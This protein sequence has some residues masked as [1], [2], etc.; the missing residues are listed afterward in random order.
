MKRK[1]IL[2]ILIAI[3]MIVF[4]QET[5]RGFFPQAWPGKQVDLLIENEGM[6]FAATIT[7]PEDIEQ[8]C[9]AVLLLPGFLGERD[10][11]PVTGT[12]VPAEGNRLQGMF[13]YLALELAKSGYISLRIDY[14]YSGRSEGYWQ[15][16]TF[17]SE[18]SDALAA[19]NYLES[20]PAVDKNK[21]AV[22]GLSLGGALASCLSSNQLI[23][24]IVLWSAAPE[25]NILEIM[26]P[27]EKQTELNETGIVT[28]T[29]PWGETTTMKK[30]FFDSLK[31]AN[32]LEEISKFKGPLLSICGSNDALVSPQPQQALKFLEI[33]EGEEKLVM[34]NADHTFDNFVG[35]NKISQAI[36]E[37]I[38]WLDMYL[39]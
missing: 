8:S 28:F 36:K 32:P 15:D 4:S 6:F 20:N 35:P 5:I 19:L 18:L 27:P 34:L 13:E 10:E 25:L 2:V 16:I 38:D 21:I 31:D 39:K 17:S 22:C 1:V 11:L 12:H 37:T 30:A 14:R 33:H 7:Y 23:K 9:P 29:L 24:V 26:V 3:T